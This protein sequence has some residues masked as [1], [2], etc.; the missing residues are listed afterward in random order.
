[1]ERKKNVLVK[2]QSLTQQHYI[3]VLGLC[4][5]FFSTPF[6]LAI[7]SDAAETI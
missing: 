2:G 5:P 3:I 1:M 6:Y 4:R 7:F